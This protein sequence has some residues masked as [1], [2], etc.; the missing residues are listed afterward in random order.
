M[1]TAFAR[2]EK[3]GPDRIQWDTDG[4]MRLD[5]VGLVDFPNAHRGLQHAHPFW[6]LIFIGGGKGRFHLEDQVKTCAADDILLVHPGMKHR[7][8]A[9]NSDT[10]EQ[11][12]I[13]FSFDF[14]LQ[15]SHSLALPFTLP[16]GSS[17]DRIKADLRQSLDRLKQSGGQQDI[18]AIRS[19]LLHV[20][21][22]VVGF[23]TASD[24]GKENLDASHYG[25]LVR[26]AEEYLQANLRT[27]VT[28]RDLARHFCLSPKYFGEIFKSRT[29]HSVKEYQ[30]NI[31]MERAMELLRD[32]SLSITKI[33]EEV[34]LEDQAYFSRVFKS[35]YQIPPR[36][37]R[38]RPVT[39]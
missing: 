30:R 35:R 29:G 7:F 2:P 28:V 13:G 26:S 15:A 4:G 19:R 37:I 8:E 20:M 39:A 25:S 32:S 38:N 16:S 21:S 34:G 1:L 6:E 31:R 12:Y 10:L 22:S 27:A 14:P 5:L 9:A 24:P 36:Q 23:L 17:A 18:G 33:A 3:L 11:F